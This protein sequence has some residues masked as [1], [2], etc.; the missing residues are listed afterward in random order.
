MKKLITIPSA[1]AGIL[2]ASIAAAG[3]A[4]GNNLAFTEATGNS[5]SYTTFTNNLANAFAAN[6]GGDLFA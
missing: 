2:A 1:I 6:S 3:A 4:N 5:D